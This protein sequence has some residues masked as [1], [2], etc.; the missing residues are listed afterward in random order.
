MTEQHMNGMD[1]P[2]TALEIFLSLRFFTATER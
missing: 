2:L 1:A